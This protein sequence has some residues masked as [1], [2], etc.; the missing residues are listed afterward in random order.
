MHSRY[1]QYFRGGN[2]RRGTSED[3]LSGLCDEA[4]SYDEWIKHPLQGIR[5]MRTYVEQTNSQTHS[6]TL[7]KGS[8]T[9][10]LAVAE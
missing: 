4:S 3:R 1:F 7:A 5:M 9:L 10:S 8:K 2:H 6:A